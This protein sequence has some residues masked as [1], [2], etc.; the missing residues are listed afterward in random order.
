MLAQIADKAA[1]V[2][3][4]L[5]GDALRRRIADLEHELERVRL[6]AADRRGP[7]RAEGRTSAAP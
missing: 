5:D 4:K 7:S 3:A 2:F 6:A 1:A